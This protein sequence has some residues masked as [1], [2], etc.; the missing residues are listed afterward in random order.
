MYSKFILN[1]YIVY[2]L[3]NWSG[4]PSNDF[5]IRNC[6]F[7]TAKLARNTIKRKFFYNGQRLAFDAAGSW[8]F[9]NNF[10]RNVVIFGN[11]NSSSIHTDNCKINLLVLDW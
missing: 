6:L 2:K 10:G 8:N 7:G 11:D 1:L 9:G 4:N 5:K 3:N